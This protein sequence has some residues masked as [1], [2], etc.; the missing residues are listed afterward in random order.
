MF[1]PIEGSLVIVTIKPLD[2]QILF[3]IDTNTGQITELV[4]KQGSLS[5][6]NWSPDGTRIAYRSSFFHSQIL[7]TVT[8]TEQTITVFENHSPDENFYPDEWSPDASN[9]LYDAVI[10]GFPQILYRLYLMDI[11][12]SVL[13]EI[14]SFQTPAIF[15]EIPSSSTSDIA[16][17][18]IRSVQ[19]NPVYGNWIMLQFEAFDASLLDD[20]T[21]PPDLN[22]FL[23]SSVS[24]LWNYETDQMINLDQLVD[25]RIRT[26]ELQWNPDGSKLF[27]NTY[28][29]SK[30]LSEVYL[31]SFSP[32]GVLSVL[33]SAVT[34]H[35]AEF[36]LGAGDLII[37]RTLDTSTLANTYYIAEIINGQLHETEFFR[38]EDTRFSSTGGSDWYIRATEEEKRLLTCTFD[39]SLETRLAVG[40]RGRVTVNDETYELRS[41]P[42]TDADIITQMPEDTEFDVIGEPWCANGYRW[43]QIQ[44]TD[45]MIGY[46]AEA[47]HDTYF[48][49]P[50]L[51]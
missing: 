51:P 31:F 42:G 40:V 1:L 4:Q 5:S 44:L 16:V 17:Y 11:N 25:S 26:E 43:W 24:V 36:W 48:L 34:E 30:R 15:P 12:T 35:T 13:T 32:T 14:E 22:P 46:T 23:G 27:A 47:D 49:E 6:P 37:T 10:V 29:H 2:Q 39:L 45:G 28:N 21:T 19:R 7:D 38:I 50:A 8:G 3:I 20:P 33:D 9:I 18:G 41:A